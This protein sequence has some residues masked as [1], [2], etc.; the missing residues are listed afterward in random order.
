[1]KVLQ[2]VSEITK[3]SCQAI[4][5]DDKLIAV[6]KKNEPRSLVTDICIWSS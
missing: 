3:S 1:M 5:A 4:C 6:W 2:I